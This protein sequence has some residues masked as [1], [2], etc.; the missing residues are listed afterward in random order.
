LAA[1]NTASLAW[2]CAS[3]A[4]ARSADSASWAACAALDVPPEFS[5]RQRARGAAADELAG[6]AVRSLRLGFEADAVDRAID[7]RN[8]EDVGDEFAQA[9]VPGEVDRLEPNVLGVGEPLLVHIP[10][11]HSCR[12][13]NARGCRGCEAD[14]P[15]TGDVYGRTD[16]IR[17]PGHGN[18]VST[19]HQTQPDF[20]LWTRG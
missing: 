7:F 1:S 3:T 19:A 17:M 5:E 13:E 16:A 10:D 2:R 20:R 11:Q 4:A 14:R 8:A 12:A 15:C 9:I 18:R 6:L